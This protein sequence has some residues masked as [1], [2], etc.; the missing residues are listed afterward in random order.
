M[1]G[2]LLKWDVG[3]QINLKNLTYSLEHN[4]IEISIIR[5]INIRTYISKW[6]RIKLAL[7]HFLEIIIEV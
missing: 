7:N 5:T 6:K 2:L 3:T 1:W 4:D